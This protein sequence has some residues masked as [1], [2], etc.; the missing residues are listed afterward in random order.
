MFFALLFIL[1]FVIIFLCTLFTVRIDGVS[2]SV[3]LLFSYYLQFFMS[4]RVNH[5]HGIQN[6]VRD[7]RRQQVT[8]SSTGYVIFIQFFVCVLFLFFSQFYFIACFFRF[9][10]CLRV[11]KFLRLYRSISLSLTM[12]P[13]SFFV[14]FFSW[15]FFGSILLF[16]QNSIQCNEWRVQLGYEL[17]KN[18][19]KSEAHKN[20]NDEDEKKK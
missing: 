9:G 12:S 11:Y 8:L 4:S 15:Y 13:C 6:D 14:L 17:K 20:T 3:C 18:N 5:Q 16:K 7:T 19:R 1:F 2:L 10:I